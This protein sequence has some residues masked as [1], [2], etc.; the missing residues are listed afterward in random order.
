M[1]DKDS[2]ALSIISA[3]MSLVLVKV[4]QPAQKNKIRQ[5]NLKNTFLCI[6]SIKKSSTT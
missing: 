6:L 3:L 1:S 5:N 4:V 2:R